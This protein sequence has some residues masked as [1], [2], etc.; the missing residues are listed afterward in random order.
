MICLLDNGHG[1]NTLGKCSPDKTVREYA[2]ARKLVNAISEK[3]KEENI[4][5]QIIVP[6]ETDIPIN[7]RIKRVNDICQKRNDCFLISVHLNAGGNGSTWTNAKG[8]SV[9]V[10]KNAS[11][12]S[13]VIASTFTTHA[14]ELN[15]MGNRSIPKEGYWIWSWSKYDIALLKYT[16]CPAILTENLFQD[17]KEDIKYLLSEEGF[18]TLVQLHIDVIKKL[19]EKNELWQKS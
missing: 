16:N 5:Y 15:L 14:K 17:N 7:T 12:K 19:N 18:N 9:F 10:S 8:W 6:E 1:V 3:L 11:K 13:K 4:E 2:Y